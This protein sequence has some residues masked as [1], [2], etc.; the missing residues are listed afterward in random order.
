[1]IRKVDVLVEIG[2]DGF[3]SCHMVDE[4]PD[5]ALLGFG[6]TIA[7][8]KKD[9]IETYREIKEMLEEDGKEV[10]ELEFEWHYDMQAFF[11]YFSFLNVSK[12]AEIAGINASLMRK[13]AAGIANPGEAQYNK[14]YTAIKGIVKEL[15]A[16]AS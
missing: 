7:E 4:F 16:A 9:L 13:Y 11:K 1:M 8:A 10:P 3:V 12:V 14:L 15:A 2:S 5:F 6:D